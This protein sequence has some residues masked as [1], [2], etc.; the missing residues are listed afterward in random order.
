M[1]SGID[2]IGAMC[3]SNVLNTLYCIGS[4]IAYQFKELEDTTNK[5]CK[6]RKIGKG[7][8]GAVYKAVLRHVPVAVKLLTDVCYHLQKVCGLCSQLLELPIP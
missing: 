2:V 3:C 5:F 1:V 4:V 7:G 8:F 6:E